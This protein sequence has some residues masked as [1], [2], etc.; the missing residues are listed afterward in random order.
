MFEIPQN[1]HVI[2]FSEHGSAIPIH[3]AVEVSCPTIEEGED[4]GKGKGKSDI[5]QH[6]SCAPPLDAHRCS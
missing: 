6:S 4:E 1:V 5:L 2:K 3:E